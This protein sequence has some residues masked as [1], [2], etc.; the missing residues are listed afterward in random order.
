MKERLKHLKNQY[1]ELTID[2][3]NSTIGRNIKSNIEY[4]TK[5]IKK[6]DEKRS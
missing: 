2:E 5:E 1:K 6:L 4:L 3:R